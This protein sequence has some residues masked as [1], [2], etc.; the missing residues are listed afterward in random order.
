MLLVSIQ[1]FFRIQNAI[2]G[3]ALNEKKPVTVV[4]GFSIIFILTL[5]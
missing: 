2:Y 1:L 5:V 4:T 3:Q